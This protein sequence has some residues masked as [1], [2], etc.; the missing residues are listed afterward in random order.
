MTKN[1]THKTIPVPL[2]VYTPI[3]AS[4]V[5]FFTHTY[6]CGRPGVG[7]DCMGIGMVSWVWFISCLYSPETEGG[8][9][10]KGR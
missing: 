3:P 6:I 8:N 2:H 9:Y 4:L 10:A 5:F 1:H 7:T